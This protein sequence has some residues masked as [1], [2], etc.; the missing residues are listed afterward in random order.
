[1]NKIRMIYRP[2]VSKLIRSSKMFRVLILILYVVTISSIGY[3]SI[4]NKT[5]TISALFEILIVTII[6]LLLFVLHSSAHFQGRKNE[7]SNI[8]IERSLI[9]LSNSLPRSI[10]DE[11]NKSI[12]SNSDTVGKSIK[13]ELQKIETN[14]NILTDLQSMQ[15]A[16]SQSSV[17][18]STR[19]V[20]NTIK[21]LLVEHE[22]TSSVKRI[23]ERD[24][25]A[26]QINSLFTDH[27]FKSLIN[28]QKINAEIILIK[29]EIENLEKTLDKQ[30]IN[31]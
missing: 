18:D 22:K 28:L 11:L 20:R 24:E 19:L 2:M 4:N 14:L 26:K 10:I 6:S 16:D 21:N 25:N 9:R 1:M 27:S 17:Q 7:L 31:D 5:N 29:H 23:I 3:H 15:F 12:R 13:I 30:I 8:R